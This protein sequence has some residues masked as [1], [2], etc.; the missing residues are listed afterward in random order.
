MKENRVD[1]RFANWMI[2]F[3]LIYVLILFIFFVV[4]R[5][6][7]SDITF[8]IGL[9]AFLVIVIGL[10]AA[11]TLNA[12][13]KARLALLFGSLLVSTL[14]IE[15]ILLFQQVLQ[16]QQAEN[17]HSQ[18]AE[19]RMDSRNR[20]EVANDLQASGIE[21][22]PYVAPSILLTM[23]SDEE[24]LPFLPLAG[25]SNVVT[26]FCDESSGH[27]IYQ[28][29]QYGFNNPSNQFANQQI[30]AV[31][32]GDSFTHGACVSRQH[33][34]AAQLNELGLANYNVAISGNG[35]LVELASIRE[36]GSALEPPI[37]LWFYFEGNDLWNLLSERS[38]LL[39]NYLDPDFSQK[40]LTRQA[41]TDVLLHR[42]LEK[43]QERANE[44]VSFEPFDESTGRASIVQFIKLT[45]L[46]ELVAESVGDIL[47]SEQPSSNTLL[48]QL[49]LFKQVMARA[50]EEVDAWG[51]TL[52]FVY[53]PSPQRYLANSR[54]PVQLFHDDVLSI[55]SDLGIPIID[56]KPVFDEHNAPRELFALPVWSHYSPAG[57]KLVSQEV[58]KYISRHHDD[59]GQTIK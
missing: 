11:L 45:A 19:I 59:L 13:L 8:Y 58:Y 9:A 7:R 42:Y 53:L 31:L 16:R 15:G 27:S 35:P 21:A 14:M 48:E 30:Q 4:G 22:Y 6:E 44:I 5:E 33:T 56:M 51:G 26:V 43:A 24:P 40:L 55:V 32:V 57:Y 2:Y 18:V 54:G 36:F 1:F 12:E 29:D 50:T 52:Y 34:I 3:E 37:V 46:R 25:I 39:L 41:E 28:S 47:R 23:D 17:V 10:C 49:P 20:V 38:S